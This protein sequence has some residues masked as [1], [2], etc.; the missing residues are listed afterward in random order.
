MGLYLY[1]HRG[2]NSVASL[3]PFTKEYILQVENRYG[4][5]KAHKFVLPSISEYPDSFTIKEGKNQSE[6]GLGSDGV[7]TA[8]Y[9]NYVIKDSM[10][11]TCHIHS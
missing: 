2:N 8:P 6:K 3:P 1:L 5:H 10:H 11:I 4:Q 7:L 9:D